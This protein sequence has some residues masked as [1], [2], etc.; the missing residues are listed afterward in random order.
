M[1][2]NPKTVADLEK[3]LTKPLS[4]MGSIHLSKTEQGTL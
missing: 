1:R 4:I 2:N 3:G